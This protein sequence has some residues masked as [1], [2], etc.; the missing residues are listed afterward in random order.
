MKF[1]GDISAS[2][3]GGCLP[4]HAVLQPGES[5]DLLPLAPWLVQQFGEGDLSFAENDQVN[6]FVEEEIFGPLHV[7]PARDH[8]Q[9]RD[10]L[11][12]SG[13]NVEKFSDVPSV[14]T[15]SQNRLFPPRGRGSSNRSD[16]LRPGFFQPDLGILPLEEMDQI[17]FG[18]LGRRSV[19][20]EKCF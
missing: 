20:Q 10:I 17:D 7:R 9:F 4:D 3:A 2:R 11:F 8:Q 1:R 13:G 12:C 16:L 19:L 6:G 14:A 15:Q 5:L 18:V